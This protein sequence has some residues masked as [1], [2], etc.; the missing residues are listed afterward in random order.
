MLF[1]DVLRSC[2]EST[3]HCIYPIATR[4]MIIFYVYFVYLIYLFLSC[5]VLKVPFI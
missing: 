5:M 4:Y 2:C 1:E 3:L